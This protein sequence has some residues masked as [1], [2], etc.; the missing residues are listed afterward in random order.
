[1]NYLMINIFLYSLIF[2]HYDKYNTFLFY[3]YRNTHKILIN[4]NFKKYLI[5]KNI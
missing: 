1:M 4:K 5:T 2:K 3:T